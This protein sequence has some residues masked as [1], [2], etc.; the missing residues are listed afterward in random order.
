MFAAGADGAVGGA[1]GFLGAELVDP[2]VFTVSALIKAVIF[3]N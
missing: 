1:N 2:D 3:A